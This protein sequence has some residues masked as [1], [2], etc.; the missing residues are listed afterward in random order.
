MTETL[1]QPPGLQRFPSGIAGLDR[2]LDGGL[3]IGGNYLVMGPPGAGKTI[4]G[5]QLC[6]HHIATGGRAIYLSLLAETS[7][8]LLAALEPFTFYTPDPVGDA[9][10]YFSSYGV[11]EQEGLEGLLKL[12]RT[13]TRSRRATLLI[14][15]GTAVLE[16]VSSPQDWMR[17]LHGLYVCAEITRCT[18]VLLM[19]TPQ[20]TDLSREQ[21]IV[22]GLIELTMPTYGMRTARELRVRKFRGSAF[23]EGWHPY[24]ITE[25]GIVV[26]PRT[27]EL[28][29][30]APVALPGTA[31]SPEH[32]SKKRMGIA[33]LD[34]MMRGGV[35][36]GSTTL[37]LGASGTGKTLLGS[38]FLLAGSAQGEPGLYFGFSET[39]SRLERKLAC[40]GLDITSAQAQGQLEVLWQSALQSILDVPAE[41][42][43]EA[44]QRGSVQRLFID[45]LGG[46]QRA[47]ASAERLDLFL[48]A[49]LSELQ[50]LEVTTICSVELP[51]L[52]SPV[53]ELPQA[54]STIAELADNLLFLRYVELESQLYRLISILKMRESGYDTAIREFRIT[55][56]GL[57]VAPTFVSAQAILTGVALPTS[58]EEQNAPFAAEAG[59]VQERKP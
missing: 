20:S 55:D 18:T 50:A 47:V 35:P 23:L 34:E 58:R 29:A 27:E 59:D 3:F 31:A 43:L 6:F 2:I 8:R 45:G 37:L 24:A 9:L 26:H 14:M 1:E 5:N 56:Q 13:E 49:L 21:T 22:E 30:A 11:L 54:I 12:I 41:R 36:A 51:A 7:S 32:V 46:F 53:L 17:F 44:T 10:T 42:L 28:L 25:A 39:P 15:D 16:G 40:F 4:L 33:R 48:A 52:F 57:D 19:Q 38:H